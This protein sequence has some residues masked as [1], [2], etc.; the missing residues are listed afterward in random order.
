MGQ[1]GTFEIIRRMW[2]E[3]R[4]DVQG[5]LPNDLLARGVSSANVLPNYH[6]RD[7]A[8]LLYNTI[9]SYVT[10]VIEGHYDTKADLLNDHEIQ[11]WTKEMIAEPPE[12]F[13]IKGVPGNG[14]FTAMDDVI[15]TVT[16]IIFVSS[17]GYSAANSQQYDSYGFPACYPSILRG[18]P[19][20]SK[21]DVTE[22]DI[23]QHLPDKLKTLDIM[24]IT[25]ILSERSTKTLGDFDIRY[26]YDPIG[27]NA[28]E[29][30][31]KDLIKVGKL[32]NERNKQR[33]SPYLCLHPT[34]IP[35]APS[36]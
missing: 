10:K 32:I 28:T 26:Q 7:D 24:V 4:L 19:P 21:D 23:L 25:N 30:F 11:A 29:E 3:W 2:N 27:Q 18:N 6:Y 16:S 36:I 22:E 15:Q 13:G 14:Q 9:F 8:M 35:N 33:Q 34:C 20:I 31:A 12:G 17:V 5:T 1:I